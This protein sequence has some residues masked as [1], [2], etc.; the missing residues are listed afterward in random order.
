MMDPRFSLAD[1]AATSA[2]PVSPGELSE[3]APDLC[4]GIF[5]GPPPADLSAALRGRPIDLHK[6]R[7]IAPAL[8]SE[9]IK[10]G[11]RN[12]VEAAYLL[13]TDEKTARNFLAA[14]NGPSWPVVAATLRALPREARLA[15]VD[16]LIGAA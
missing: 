2:R 11:T 8:W 14:R 3:L 15:T 1:H 12:S 4:A 13:S 5:A 6:M 10:A 16:Y 9:M 7:C